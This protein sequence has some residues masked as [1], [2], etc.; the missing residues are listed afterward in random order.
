MHEHE[1]QAWARGHRRIA[2]IDEAGRG[3]L[4][5]P[6]V[7]AA[8]ILDPSLWADDGPL[9]DVDDSKK[10]A[11]RRRA[12][13]YDRLRQAD[14]VWFGIGV[15]TVDEIDRLNILRATHLAMGRAVEA[16]AEPPDYL[17]VDG[18]P[19]PGLPAPSEALVKGDAR[20]RSIAAASILAKVTRDRIMQALDREYPVYGFAAHKGYGTRAHRDA[21]ERHG[22]CPAHRR[23][24]A[25]VR[26]MTLNL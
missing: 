14:G 13:I 3:P 1:Q 25:P 19:V 6:V 2:G 9:S 24:F 18:R 22:P 7:A 20:S 8:A 10:I 12:L 21:L 26:L 16:L 23:S 15:A 11:P 17:L 4:A 5:G